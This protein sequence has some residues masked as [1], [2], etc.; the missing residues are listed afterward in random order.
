MENN[1]LCIYMK[2]GKCGCKGKHRKGAKKRHSM[3]GRHPPKNLRVG[4]CSGNEPDNVLLG[5][6]GKQQKNRIEKRPKVS[7]RKGIVFVN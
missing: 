2:N 3:V 1:I 5:K 7:H 4:C 6:Y